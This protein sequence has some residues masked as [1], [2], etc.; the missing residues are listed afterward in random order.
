MKNF[1]ALIIAGGRGKRFWPLSR[2]HRPKQFLNLT[3][4]QSLLQDTFNRISADFP[5]ERIWV[6]TLKDYKSSVA[7]ELPDIPEENIIE[8][9]VGRNTAAAIGLGALHIRRRCS[10]AVMAALPAD[11]KIGERSIFIKTLKKGADLAFREKAL[12]TIGI[13]PSYPS[14][15]YGYIKVQGSTPHFPEKVRGKAQSPEDDSQ[16]WEW[17]EGF[18]EKPDYQTAKEYVQSGDYFW[19]SGIFIWE[20]EEILRQISLFRPGMYKSLMRIEDVIDTGRERRVKEEVYM[21]IEP[22]SID[23]GIMEKADRIVMMHGLFHWD[24][25]GSWSSIRRYLKDSGSGMKVKGRTINVGSHDCLVF[26]PEKL[27][28]LV[29]V[30]SLIVVEEG[31]AIL[32]MDAGKEQE[33]R[34]VVSTLE[35]NAWEEYL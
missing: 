31:D 9:P 23:Y 33:V 2:L 32:I 28:A 8:E 21:D 17:V 6:V 11:H 4:A 16:V 29:G 7:R 25:L 27:V 19:N 15:G 18:T 30:E 1:H 3:G 12:V 34:E 24:D 35:K 5:P 13:P 20:V 10:S 22:I 26:N 14:T